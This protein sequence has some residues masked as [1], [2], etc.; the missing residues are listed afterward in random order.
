MVTSWGAR[1]FLGGLAVG[2]ALT[3]ASA[4]ALFSIVAVLLA[5][6][7]ITALVDGSAQQLADDIIAQIDFPDTTN[8]D[9]FRNI[10]DFFDAI[11]PN[12]FIPFY[13]DIFS[14]R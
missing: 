11:N 7:G 14:Q 4:P 8:F 10:G 9:Q 1:H 3:S 13:E 5:E 6:R 2:A 12:P